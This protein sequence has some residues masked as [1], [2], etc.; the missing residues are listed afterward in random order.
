MKKILL[1]L[2]SVTLITKVCIAQHALTAQDRKNYSLTIDQTKTWKRHTVTRHSKKFDFTL[3]PLTLTNHSNTILRYSVFSCSWYEIYRTNNP[4]VLVDTWNCDTNLP[5]VATILPH[6]SL[7]KNI[8]VL[9]DRNMKGH[10]LRFRLGIHLNK[11]LK[12]DTKIELIHN[13]SGQPD[14]YKN[15]LIW[16]NEV[17]MPL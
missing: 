11:I 9:I 1:F 13:Y 6:K 10:V 5:D 16:S 8:P 2:V 17:S 14:K 4:A 12:G 15:I 3:V 7:V